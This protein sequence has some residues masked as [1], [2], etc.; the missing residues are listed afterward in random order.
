MSPRPMTH[1]RWKLFPL[2]IRTSLVAIVLLPLAI[3]IGLASTVVASQSSIRGQAVTARRSSLYLDSLLRAR[4][5]VYTE[6]VDTASIVAAQAYHV[7]NA[8]LNSLMGLNVRAAMIDARRAVDHQKVFRP[9]GVFAPEYAQ[10]VALRR[11]VTRG[12]ASPVEVESFFNGFGSTIDAL[13]ETTFKTLAEDQPVGRFGRYEEPA[14]SPQL[15]LRRLHVRSRRGEPAGWWISGDGADDCVHPGG[16]RESHCQSPPVRGDDVELSRRARPAGR[17]RVEGTGERPTRPQFRELCHARHRGR[18]G[19]AEC[20]RT[21][22]DTAAISAIAKSEVE[23]ANSLTNVVLASSA[24]LRVATASQAALGHACPHLT[25]LF[26]LL[27]VLG[28]IGSVLAFGRAIRRP[29]AHIASALKSVQAGR[30]RVPPTRRDRTT[31]DLAGV[32]GVQRD[33]L[34]AAR[35][36]GTGHRTLQRRARRPRTATPAARANGRG[37][38]VGTQQASGIGASQ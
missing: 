24:D 37:S 6:Y 8:E 5:D 30:A 18:A 31:G 14:C 20:R 4:I 19:E 22:D 26:M 9:L 2:S 15:L 33:V 29:L 23:W 12:S 13:W 11:A 32:R 16:D 21:P 7:S 36:A 1:H 10:L 35:R 3:S 34:D 27:L 17:R 38:A 28:A 25:F